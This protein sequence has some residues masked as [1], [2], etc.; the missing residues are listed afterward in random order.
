MDSLFLL[1]YLYS[2][3]QYIRCPMASSGLLV[4]ALGLAA[5]LEDTASAKV[6]LYRLFEFSVA[7]PHTISKEPL[8]R[9]CDQHRLRVPVVGET[10]NILLRVLQWV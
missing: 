4:A 6:P 7:N 9:G 2:Y 8:H 1:I 5:G 3:T 10:N